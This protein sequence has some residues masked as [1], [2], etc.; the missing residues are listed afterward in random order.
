MNGATKQKAM[1]VL[2]PLL[3]IVLIFVVLKVFGSP[4]VTNVK[5]QLPEPA[6]EHGDS[7]NI[8]DWKIP[9]PYP[10]TSRDPMQR[11]PQISPETKAETR[12]TDGEEDPGLI[13]KGIVYSKEDPVA[14]I[15]THIVHEGDRISGATVV[16]ISKDSVEFEI[17]DKR[18]TQRVE[19][20]E[21]APIKVPEPKKE[22]LESLQ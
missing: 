7:N 19:R 5:A 16:R 11:S 22:R 6:S 12:Q 21:E 18:W 20:Q 9:A 4:S 3:A 1:A 17:N 8:I 13:V 10:A 14:V 2:V 15:G